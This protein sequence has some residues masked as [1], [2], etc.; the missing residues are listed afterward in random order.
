MVTVVSLLRCCWSSKSAHPLESVARSLDLSRLFLAAVLMV[1][2]LAG[3]CLVGTCLDSLVF[4]PDCLWQRSYRPEAAGAMFWTWSEVSL[5]VLDSL[6]CCFVILLFRGFFAISIELMIPVPLLACSSL[7]W[8]LLYFSWLSFDRLVPTPTD[9]D[10]PCILFFLNAVDLIPMPVSAPPSTIIS[11]PPPLVP[12]TSP[13]HFSL[14]YLAPTILPSLL[15]MLFNVT[16]ASEIDESW[17]FWSWR[18]DRLFSPL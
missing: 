16:I 5:I 6:F 17:T 4:L 18:S 2:L 10:I 15:F 13:P 14:V 11:T 3:N 9:Y 8:F 7:F 12:T 1:L